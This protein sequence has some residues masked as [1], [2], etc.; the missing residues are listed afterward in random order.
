MP[1]L[2]GR[3]VRTV[4]T[5]ERFV[6]VGTDNGLSRYDKNLGTWKNY[7]QTGGSE[8]IATH[9]GHWHRHRPKSRGMLSDN[10]VSSIV[11]DEQY[12]WVGTRDGANRFDK[13]ALRWDQYK[14]E[15]GLPANNV[16]SV[17]TDGNNIWVGTHSGIGKY[18][19]TAD[20]LNAWIAYTSGTEIQPS[21]V[22]KE[23][24]ESLVTDEIWCITAS[25]KHVWVGT[26]RGV[27]KYDIGRDIW[28]TITAEDGLASDEVSC[29]AVNGD[30]IWFGSDRGVTFYNETTEDWRA[31]TT[32]DGLVS[33][34]ITTIGVD[35][36][37]VWIGTY[38]AGISRYD[39]LK[40]SWT[41]YT[42]ED[43]LAHNGILSMAIGNTYVWFGTYRGLSRFDKRTGIWTTFTEAYGPE[44]ILR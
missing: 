40:N 25:Q 12:V 23:F 16:T 38:N 37:D 19:R 28:K 21:A 8:E 35:G 43:G 34:K 4:D 26:R 14:T 2:S 42:R 36:T 18:P 30:R 44:D 10:A 1:T 5:D 32:K 31:Y 6:W 15:H 20:D 17:S 11:A 7:K 27:S 41:T 24:A 22:S 29:I 39:Q 13:I 33:D 9:N 3:T